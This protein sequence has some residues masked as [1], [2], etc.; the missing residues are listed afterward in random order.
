MQTN[1]LRQRRWRVITDN[2][3]CHNEQPLH[4]ISEQEKRRILAEVELKQSA[5]KLR[6][7]LL[8][9]NKALKTQVYQQKEK[10]SKLNDAKQ[11]CD[12]T[13]EQMNAKVTKMKEQNYELILELSQLDH[14][15]DLERKRLN[16]TRLTLE[17][18]ERKLLETQRRLEET[19][20]ELWKEQSLRMDLQ[21][22]LKDEQ[23]QRR[24]VVT[25]LQNEV[26]RYKEE[27]EQDKINH[28]AAMRE[29]QKE[30]HAL[31]VQRDE[32]MKQQ[33]KLEDENKRH[34]VELVHIR[35]EKESLMAEHKQLIGKHEAA[36]KELDM[37]ERLKRQIETQNIHA[38]RP[39][40]L[41]CTQISSSMQPIQQYPNPGLNNMYEGLKRQTES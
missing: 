12:E 23:N 4:G 41:L 19:T 17:E 36:L 25:S 2:T 31:H 18:T 8:A 24:E 35:R 6:Q 20:E 11:R 13:I 1:L 14:S 29:K 5:F 9:E 21:N 38:Y 10:F 28:D 32:Y 40:E 34:N 7:E 33:K 30:K 37:Y 26:N 39:E 22:K 27:L 16:E 15:L 3:Q